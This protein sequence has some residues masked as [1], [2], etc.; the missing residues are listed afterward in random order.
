MHAYVK[1][2][3]AAVYKA[4]VICFVEKPGEAGV[5]VDKRMQF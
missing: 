2:A 4:T 1:N 3:T 5:F